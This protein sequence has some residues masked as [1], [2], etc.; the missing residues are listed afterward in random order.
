MLTGLTMGESPSETK[1][2]ASTDLKPPKGSPSCLIKDARV[3]PE[4]SSTLTTVADGEKGY[5][6]LNLVT[7]D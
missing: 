4:R 7:S 5:L 2:N 6:S 1:K 3:S